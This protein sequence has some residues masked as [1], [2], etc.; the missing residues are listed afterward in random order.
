MTLGRSLPS[1]LQ[2]ESAV[3]AAPG[4]TIDSLVGN[5]PLLRL[6]L[7]SRGLPGSVELYAKAEWTNPSGSV[8]DRPALNI[9]QR[10]EQDGSLH[11]GKILLD[12]SS[13]NMG[14]AY[15][16]LGTA[17]GYHVT[18]VVPA[19]ASPE[20]QAILRSYGVTLVLSDP[21]EGSDGAIRK[22]RE[23]Y[24]AD[25]ERYFFADQYNNPANWQAHYE[26]TGAE[27]WR[28]TEGRITH[29]VA[30]L[31][32][33]GTMM[34]TGRR[35]REAN[36]DIK[37][38]AFQ[39]DSPFHGLEGLKHMPAAIVPGIYDSDLPDQTLG[40]KTEDAHAM[41]RKMVREEGLLVGVSSGAALCAALTIACELEDG[42]V[43]TVFPDNGYKYLT[44]KF[45]AAEDGKA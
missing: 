20:R 21:L 34:G 7:I 39:P 4:R 16:M 10:A 43:V 42:I 23:L 27:I 25:P 33:S 5:T 31:G 45:W 29:F 26:G 1:S 40:I 3:R 12:S 18:L 37:L 30:G 41:C 14:I 15:A 11:P 24:E 35:L 32:T 2:P 6:P 8:K 28:E 19:N 13:G 44:E 36:P 38:I 22:V 9:I 17:R